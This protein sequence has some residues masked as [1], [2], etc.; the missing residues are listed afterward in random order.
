[1]TPYPIVKRYEYPTLSAITYPTGGRV[2]NTPHGHQV[3]S[4]TTILSTLPK[5]GLVQWRERVGDEE[6][7]R[8]TEEACN[9]GTNMH[10]R[11]EGYVS[12]YLQGRPNDPPETDEDRIA[13]QMAENMKRFGLPDLD[14]VWG[15]EEALYC[16]HLYA[17][18]TDLIG[19]YMGKSAIIDYKSA[20]RWKRPDWV[21]SYRMQI[22]AYNFCHKA[23][24]GEGMES[25]VI[26]I[27]VRP[28][29]N[30]YSK[31]KALQRFVL[32]KSELDRYEDKWLS[33]VEKYYK[34]K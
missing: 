32:N 23:M 13:L 15:I 34:D 19:V 10:D 12:N 28:S 30:P 8:I 2:Y 33:L 29:D 4:V 14:E 27:A 5:D 26:L 1:M 9:I 11:L 7:D 24:F 21:E 3:P 25:G 16:E 6:A 20:R 18:R 17:G 31:Q 22:A